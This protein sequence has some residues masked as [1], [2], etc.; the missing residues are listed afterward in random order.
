MISRDA[1]SAAW[2]FTFFNEEDNQENLGINSKF[3]PGEL[4]IS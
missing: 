4:L 2:S 1:G 3:N